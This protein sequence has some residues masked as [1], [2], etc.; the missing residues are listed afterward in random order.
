MNNIE[1]IR[2]LVEKGTKKLNRFF[3]V[4]VVIGIVMGPLVLV[5]SRIPAWRERLAGDD[6]RLM[7]IFG[8]LMTVLFGVAIVEQLFKY[9]KDRALVWALRQS[10]RD[11]VWVYK[12]IREGRVQARTG[13]RG[14]RVAR[15]VHACFHLVDR[16]KV[17][18]WLSERE[19]D[20]LIELLKATFPHLTVGYSEEIE[21]EY[22][23]APERLRLNP[24]QVDGVKEATGGVRM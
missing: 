16:K 4:G 24:R 1:E 18:V 5:A 7:V 12:E 17:I 21:E 11:I 10:P 23:Q 19:V 6:E 15:Y 22:K 20:R 9:G 3:Y 8:G 13:G 2:S 14:A